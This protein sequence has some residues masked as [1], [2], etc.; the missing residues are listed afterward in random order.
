VVS[1]TLIITARGADM[2]RRRHENGLKYH[3]RIENELQRTSRRVENVE[4]DDRKPEPAQP[5]PVPP[6]VSQLFETVAPP[7]MAPNATH[8]PYDPHE[9]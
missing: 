7:L 9:P 8:D 3:Q 4:A 5:A 6:G 2:A 1:Y